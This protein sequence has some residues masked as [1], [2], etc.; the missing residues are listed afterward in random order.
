MRYVQGSDLKSV[1]ERER[2]AD[3][4]ARAADPGA[5][6]RRARRGAPPRPRAPRRQAGERPARRGRARLPDRLRD[7]QAGWAGDVDRHRP[8][9][10]G[11]S[12]TWRRSRSAA[13]RSTG[14]ATTTRSRACSTSAWRARRRSAARPRPRRCGRT[15]RSDA[16]VAARPA[17]RSTR[18]CAR[19]SP[20]RR[21]SGYATCTEL[22]DAARRSAL[23]LGHRRRAARGSAATLA[24]AAAARCSPPACSCSPHGRR[25]AVLAPT[26]GEDEADLG[27]IGNGVAA[28]DAAGERSRRS[29]SPPRRRA[30]SPS[31]RAPSGC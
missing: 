14:A 3:A 6:R 29:S 2:D 13:S 25:G 12:T 21:T 5:G 28:I 9:W 15:C 1:L 11:R 22:I 31:A 30:T 19:R 18:C 20:R 8:G 17:R 26:G 24:G 4:R 16:A 27:P 23:G 10:S 7:Q